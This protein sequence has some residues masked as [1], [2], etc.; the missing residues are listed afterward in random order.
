MRLVID[1]T[2]SP[3]ERCHP[4]TMRQAWPVDFPSSAIGITGPVC[5]PPQPPLWVR[6]IR[7]LFRLH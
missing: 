5:I 6:A 4:R 2:I 1:N 3:T 7:F